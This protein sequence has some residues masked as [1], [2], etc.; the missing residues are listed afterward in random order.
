MK[1]LGCVT[2][3]PQVAST[4]IEAKVQFMVTLV[5]QAITFFYNKQGG[6]V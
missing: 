4:T 2:K 3:K 1:H 6:S 5:D